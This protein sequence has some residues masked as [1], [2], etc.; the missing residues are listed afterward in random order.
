MAMLA[1]LFTFAG[2]L[3]YLHGRSMLSINHVAAYLW[4]SLSL[5]LGTLLATF[6]K[7]NG[8]LLPILAFCL[9]ITVLRKNRPTPDKRWV[10]VFLWMPLILIAA[11]FMYGLLSGN[12]Q[13]SYSRR[14]FSMLERV[15]TQPRILLDYLYYWLIPHIASPGLLTQDFPIS[16]SL[17]DPATTLPSILFI[18][19]ALF[20]ALWL[21][22]KFPYYSLAIL[23]YF[24]GHI[25]ESTLIPLEMYFEHRNYLPAAFLLLPITTGLAK[26]LETKPLRITIT[27]LVIVIPAF[28]TSA[29]ANI[30]TSEESLAYH[31]AE[32]HPESQRAMRHAALVAEKNGKYALA[33]EFIEKARGS[34]AEKV[35]VELHWFTLNCRVRPMRV[36]EKQE[37]LR[38]MRDSYFSF[39][40]YKLISST[41]EFIASGHCMDVD[42]KFAHQLIEA[43]RRNT[44]AQ[45][46]AGARFQLYMIEGNLYLLK[47]DYTK[48]IELFRRSL[49]E[50]RHAD[51]AMIQ[52]GLLASAGQYQLALEHINYVE[53]ILKSERKLG[54]LD[55]K[56]EL[57]RLKNIIE[58]DLNNEK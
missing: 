23:F 41:I 37:T 28:L 33:L 10:I 22:K 57:F 51:A 34:L 4:M 8:A 52:V 2:L 50:Y 13:S 46:S 18:I 11:Y 19:S 25:I 7:E 58:A 42:I 5:I 49:D 30:W 53:R 14:T 20:S 27:I 31:W 24:T 45:N 1:T 6:S 12:I 36:E 55:Y 35:A 17:F 15:L 38:K 21:R 39:R 54:E 43:L 3:G 32:I 29:R 44:T 9:E 56:A 40:S 48:A 47:K 16:K 26:H